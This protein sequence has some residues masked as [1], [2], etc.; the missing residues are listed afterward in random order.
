MPN[1]L[2]LK[3]GFYWVHCEGP[4]GPCV[5]LAR[6]YGYS[7]MFELFDDHRNVYPSY[8]DLG[9]VWLHKWKVLHVEPVQR[10]EFRRAP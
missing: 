6:H 7:G 4:D 1:L 5:L 8:D 10:P 3:P 2:E 9:A